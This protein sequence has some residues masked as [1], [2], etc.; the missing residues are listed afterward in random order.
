MTLRAEL[1]ARWLGT[2]AIALLVGL[3]G[4]AVLSAMAGARRTDSTLARVSR[5]ERLPDLLINPDNPDQ[6]SAFVN[7][8]KRVG[9]LPSVVTA[10]YVSGLAVVPLDANGQPDVAGVLN[11][12]FLAARDNAL[13]QTINRPALVA[14]HYPDATH[15]YDVVINE[16]E[17]RRAHLAPGSRLRLAIFDAN[18]FQNATPAHLPRPFAVHDFTVTGVMLSLD[19]AS[20]TSDDPGLISQ[21]N[22]TPALSR[23]VGERP[24]MYAGAAVGLRGGASAA[25]AMEAEVQQ[26]FAPVRVKPLGP[27]AP[28]PVNMNFQETANTLARARRAIRPYVFALWLFAL[29]AALAALAVIGQVIVRSMRPLREQRELLGS[30]GFTGRQLGA[31]AA[32]RGLVIGVLGAAIAIAIAVVA[33]LLFPLGPLRAI[34]PVKGLNIDGLV[35]AGGFA[36]IVGLAVLA[37]VLSVRRA[38]PR[39]VKYSMSVGDELAHAGMPVPLVCGTR[40]ALE[41]N[42]ENGV[43][44]RST[45]VGVTVAITALVATFVFGS[46]LNRFTSSPIRYGW[47]WTYELKIDDQSVNLSAVGQKLAAMPS[48]DAS[49]AGVYA[50]FESRGKSFAV[51]GIDRARGLPFLPMLHG[52]PP[53]TDDEIVLGASTMH[54]LRA[55]IGDH[56]HVDT[57]ADSRTFRIVG[58][59][60]FPRF[61]PYQGSDPT[62]LGVGGATT[63]HAVNTLNAAVGSPFFLVQLRPG[64]HISGSALMRTV[65]NRNDSQIGTVL[66]PQRPNDV[67]SYG[68]LKA[69][70]LVLAAVLALL[71]LG[72]AIHLL[73]AGVRG[74][75]RDIALLRTIGLTRTQTRGA[76]FIQATVL[77]AVALVVA[78]P[79]GIIA[80]TRLWTLTAHWLG[81][82][83]D[84]SLPWIAVTLVSAGAIAIANLIA[85]GPAVTAARTHP[86]VTLRTE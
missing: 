61:A 64:V 13:L 63:A 19:D 72:S 35:L 54:A 37:S 85:V 73:V 29:L 79:L 45:L 76:I 7:A 82:A 78:V 46:G 36:V 55:R 66:G 31:C 10:A 16:A 38:R 39:R 60:V 71:A 69:T 50:Q 26:L 53:V 1:A 43:P 27:G 18:E 28:Q 17:A 4:G 9:T 15:P 84:P 83:P 80:G 48:V 3:G 2:L 24:V 47:P 49:A 51:V 62:G 41:R 56:V 57:V 8:W 22:L 52:R 21:V 65:T 23:L 11:T 75:R 25:P 81:I 58:T 32:L 5:A 33:S 12:A 70:P 77:T 59:A 6:S 74:R 42:R 67:L 44:L 30:L 34:D 68:H 40:F 20:R 14:G 86:A